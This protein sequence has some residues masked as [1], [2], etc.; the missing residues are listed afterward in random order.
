M[1]SK[2]TVERARADERA[3][4][5]E[6]TS[7]EWTETERARRPMTF[8]PRPVN[9]CGSPPRGLLQSIA[10]LQ[11]RDGIGSTRVSRIHASTC[12]LASSRATP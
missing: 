2:S 4:K 6:G 9:A 1:P 5:R 7:A 12:R 10:L 11:L 3:G 8:P